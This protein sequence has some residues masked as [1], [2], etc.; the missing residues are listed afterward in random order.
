MR[1]SELVKNLTKKKGDEFSVATYLADDQLRPSIASL[2]DGGVVIS[3]P[4]K[5][6]SSKTTI[7]SKILNS[8]LSFR[9]SEFS[10][11]ENVRHSNGA[12]STKGIYDGYIITWA[13]ENNSKYGIYTQIFLHDGTPN[14]SAILINRQTSNYRGSP[15]VS[16]AGPGF[17]VMFEI[18]GLDTSNSYGIFGQLFS[19]TQTALWINCASSSECA[20]MDL[21][22]PICDTTVKVCRACLS[23]SECPKKCDTSSG[24]CVECLD[25]SHC[26]GINTLC[27]VNNTQTCV[28]CFSDQDCPVAR[29]FCNSTLRCQA[30]KSSS[31]C[32]LGKQCNTTSGRCL[33]CLTD[34]HCNNDIFL[35]RCSRDG[36]GVCVQCIT[37]GDCILNTTKPICD[38]SFC[39]EC[40]N[41]LECPFPK[42]CD[43]DFG[44]CVDCLNN[45]QCSDESKSICDPISKSCRECLE[46]SDCPHRCD[47]DSGKC[48]RCL[49]L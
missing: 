42:L 44:A 47:T 39:R 22:M 48:V 8:D 13:S 21:S 41:D 43:L 34:I 30:C 31:E 32:P 5:L 46:D 17:A 18:Y 12:I 37:N 27:D 2:M 36:S 11:V 45:S 20:A 7:I 10:V 9:I 6:D 38:S 3:W 28:E 4:S 23:H 49:I 33:D 24:K 35:P 29:P 14:G 1:K 25:D 40:Q 16:P 26:G 15:A 19:E